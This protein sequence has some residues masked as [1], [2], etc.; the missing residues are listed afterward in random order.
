MSATSRYAV[1]PAEALINRPLQ[2]PACGQPLDPGFDWDG[3][4]VKT[5]GVM[6]CCNAALTERHIAAFRAEVRAARE[7]GRG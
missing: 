1:V 2:C 4:L 7:T 3:R 6:T 5:G